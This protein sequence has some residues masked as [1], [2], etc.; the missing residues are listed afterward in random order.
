MI[1]GY[2][3]RLMPAIASY[4]SAVFAAPVSRAVHPRLGTYTCS[5]AGESSGADTII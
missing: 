3:P 1:H 5:T 2:H 4:Q